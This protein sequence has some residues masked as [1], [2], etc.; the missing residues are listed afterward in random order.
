[1]LLIVRSVRSSWSEL[2]G[3]Q[4]G[5][6]CPEQAKVG[7]MG[8]GTAT[9][10]EEQG[11]VL[12]PLQAV[13]TSVTRGDGGQASVWLLLSQ[14]N[15]DIPKGH[16]WCRETTLRN[17]HLGPVLSAGQGSQ[18]RTGKSEGEKASEDG[19]LIAAAPTPPPLG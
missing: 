9:T 1:M 7:E 8:Q 2:F 18:V 10:C 19:V 15:A 17:T 14:D 12:R 5:G 4:F 11:Q 13:P 16:I 6:H 3:P